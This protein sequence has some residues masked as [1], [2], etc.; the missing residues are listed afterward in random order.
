M[1]NL[2][3]FF[4]NEI[5]FVYQNKKYVLEVGYVNT[6]PG[7]YMRLY[8]QNGQR[9]AGSWVSKVEEKVRDSSFDFVDREIVDICIA[10][11]R[12]IEKLKAF[13]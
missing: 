12:R 8:D 6:H 3:K 9:L 2:W 1:R 13:V 4:I 7:L 5:S 10:Q 11:A